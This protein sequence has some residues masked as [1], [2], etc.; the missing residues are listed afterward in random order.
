MGIFEVL[1]L[2][3]MALFI[4]ISI[5]VLPKILKS[6]DPIADDTPLDLSRFE[7]IS[8]PTLMCLICI[9]AFAEKYLRIN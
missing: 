3:L 2:I 5:K 1:L 4:I 8:L 9:I 6:E 7:M